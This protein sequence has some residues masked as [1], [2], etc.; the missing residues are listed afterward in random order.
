MEALEVLA[1]ITRL[2]PSIVRVVAQN[3]GKFTLQGTNTYIIGRQRPYTL[4]DTGEGKEQYV[5]VLEAAL[6][7]SLPSGKSDSTDVSD[8]IISHW[9]GDHVGGLPSVLALLR[10]LWDERDTG[11]PFTPPRLHKFPLPANKLSERSDLSPIVNSLPLN[12]FTPASDHSAFHD[13]HDGQD[14]IT[15]SASFRVLHTPGHTYDSICLFIAEDR[16]LYTADTV[17]G[18][19]T[20]VFEDLQLYISSL[21]KMLDYSQSNPYEVLYPGHGPV[22]SEGTVLIETYIKH[23][24]EREAQ[25]LQVLQTTP[26]NSDDNLSWTT[27]T[28]VSKIYQ[29]YP[30]SLWTPAA[31]S[32]TLH[33]QK[34]KAD[35][36]VK[37]LDGEGVNT[38]WALNSKL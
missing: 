34:L 22:V 21:R 18:Q 29:G 14:F 35:G 13:L 30:D 33:M 25:V 2:S 7:E 16:A 32:I 20:A 36:I 6:K 17:L 27:W 31:H 1:S 28:I 8:I 24:L 11:L 10:R 12:S 4:V 23:R 38:R 15:S 26:P 5:P 9:H 3:P 37:Q 19:G